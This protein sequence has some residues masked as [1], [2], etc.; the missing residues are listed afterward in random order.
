MIFLLFPSKVLQHAQY[1]C[2]YTSQIKLRNSVKVQCPVDLVQVY[3]RTSLSRMSPLLLIAIV[4]HDNF[5]SV[6][7]FL[8]QAHAI[9]MLS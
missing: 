7:L 8:T 4:V 2:I 6:V 1:N 9:M 3:S 5:K